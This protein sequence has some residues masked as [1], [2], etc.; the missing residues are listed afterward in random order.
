M[1]SGHSGD[2]DHEEDH[3]DDFC[4]M[5]QEEDGEGEGEAD[6][7]PMDVKPDR[8]ERASDYKMLDYNQVR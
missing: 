8:D 4:M 7:E 3:D 1:H 6:E 2:D 5:S